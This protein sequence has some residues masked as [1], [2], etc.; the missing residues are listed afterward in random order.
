M[1]RLIAVVLTIAGVTVLGSSV[2]SAVII[3]EM[4]IRNNQVG[5]SLSPMSNLPN[6]ATVSDAPILKPGGTYSGR[7]EVSQPGSESNDILAEVTPYSVNSEDNYTLDYSTL[8]SR[9]K[10]TS[11]IDLDL[12]QCDVSSQESG[13]LYFVMRSKE[14]CYINYRINVPVDATGGSQRAF[15]MVQQQSSETSDGST[16]VNKLYRIGYAVNVYIDGPD[17]NYSGRVVENNI[18][19]LFWDPPVFVTNKVENDGNSDFDVK[20]HVEAKGI[21]GGANAFEY[22]SEK[23]VLADST[24]PEKITWEGSPAFGIY[25]VTQTIEMLGETHSN[26]NTVFII[27]IWLVLIIVIIIGL[28]IWALREK[29]KN[30]KK[31]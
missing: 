14:Q 26:T 12:E 4:E 16:G 21:F 18:P 6:E 20:Y 30:H 10:I 19:W 29:I 13:K 8:S 5:L 7:V 27:P 11:W 15:I 9:N 25:N 2:V 31:R 17:A 3:D 23:Y 28:L 22:N 1:N 24:R